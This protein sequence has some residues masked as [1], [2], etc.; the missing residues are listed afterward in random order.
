MILVCLCIFYKNFWVKNMDTILFTNHFDLGW[1]E[2]S[3]KIDWD[4][5]ELSGKTA[6]IS[7]KPRPPQNYYLFWV[8]HR[9]GKLSFKRGT[10]VFSFYIIGEMFRTKELFVDLMAT[11][12]VNYL[13]LVRDTKWVVTTRKTMRDFMDLHVHR[14]LEQ[15]Q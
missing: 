6:M 9:L 15:S 13:F 3:L 7:T 1:K 5:V 12:C 14:F 10:E 2:N 11:S 4:P 8:D